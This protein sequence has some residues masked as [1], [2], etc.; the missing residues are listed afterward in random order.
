MMREMVRNASQYRLAIVTALPKEFAAVEVM[1]DQHDDITVPGDSGRYTVGNIGSHPVVVTLLPSMGNNHATAVSSNLL[2]SFPTISDILMVGI[3][4][5]VPDP[6]NAENHVRLGD[7]VI[8]MDAGVM[9]FD[10]GKL[11]QVVPSGETPREQFTIRAADPPPSARLQ[12][13]VRLLEAR[14]IRGEQPWEQYI[15]RATAFENAVRPPSTKDILYDSHDPTKVIPHPRD[16]MRVSRQPKLHYGLIGSSNLLLKE[17]RLRDR[18][19]DEY[20]IR[21]IE[22]E[23]SGIASATWMSGNVGYLLIRGICDYCDS[24]KNDV[25]Q[26]Y[27]AAVA[28][29][30]ARALIESIPTD[31]AAFTTP[32][33]TDT[34]PDKLGERSIS[35][36][37]NASGSTIISGDHNTVR[38]ERERQ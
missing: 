36:G 6:S 28:A 3:A 21:A 9:Q 8:S 15:P 12:Q 35:I 4:G 11:E 18:L 34:R 37:G 33:Q 5:G 38:R 20:K 16:T 13:V 26:G 7:I 23:G 29:A 25:W 30:Y 19:R 22:M 1:L 14:R 27:A 17:P 10:F 24:H 31:I 2:R 32:Q